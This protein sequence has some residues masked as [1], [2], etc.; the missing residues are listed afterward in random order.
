M[1]TIVPGALLQTPDEDSGAQTLDRYIWQSSMAVVDL[2]AVAVSTWLA[3]PQTSFAILCERHE[4]Y[5]VIEQDRV[6]LVSVKHRDRT[7][8][9][10]TLTQVLNEGGVAHLFDR[11]QELD[12][13]YACKLVTCVGMSSGDHAKFAQLVGDL[14]RRAG[15]LSGAEQTLLRTVAK[16]LLA[17]YAK[18]TAVTRGWRTADTADPTDLFIAK[19]AAFLSVLTLEMDRSDREDLAY[20]AVPRYAVPFT[21]ALEIDSAH[22]DAIWARCEEQITRRM[23]G[24][25]PLPHGGLQQAIDHYRGVTLNSEEGV[26]GRI[27]SSSDLREV[28]D[29]CVALGLE[30]TSVPEQPAPTILTTKLINGGL[31]MTTASLAEQHAQQWR[32]YEAAVQSGGPGAYTQLASLR[33]WVHARAGGASEGAAPNGTVDG[34]AMWEDLPRQLGQI[35]EELNSPMLNEELLIGA[36]CVLA[37]ECKVWFSPIFDL[38]A[39]IAAFPR[40]LDGSAA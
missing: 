11:W 29:I 1:T 13:T 9:G 17:K 22:A 38:S 19:C 36:A 10:W 7:Q 39:G 6:T 12:E 27:L 30:P 15:E 31:T 32:E 37:S 28:V 34:R 26:L 20:S 8:G 25:G 35:P 14:P 33:R 23:R 2:F 24:R 21:D 16:K 4:D 40:R 3:E 5:V 18:T